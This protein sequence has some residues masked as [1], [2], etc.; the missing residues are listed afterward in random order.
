[1]S[2]G[3]LGL[4]AQGCYPAWTSI[5]V[6]AVQGARLGLQDDFDTFPPLRDDETYLE[7]QPTGSVFVGQL[8]AIFPGFFVHGL[9]HHYAGDYRTSRK[10]S[11]IGQFGYI[12]SL[13]GGGMLLGGYYLDKE[14]DDYDNYAYSLYGAG[15]VV[16]VVGVSYLLTA[17]IYDIVDT[18]RAVR[19]G[20]L[21][22]PRTQL[23]ES[24]DIFE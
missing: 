19:S 13:L 3:L 24:M 20:G 14:E 21:P 7:R 8:I 18:P 2:L 6:A 9:G 17:W 5:D 23:L 11:N 22:P 12:L 15:G 1:M 4:T 16:S 10:L